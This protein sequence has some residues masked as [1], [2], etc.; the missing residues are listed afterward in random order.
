MHEVCATRLCQY[1]QDVKVSNSHALRP[2]TPVVR[3][4]HPSSLA[5]SSWACSSCIVSY[6]SRPSGDCKVSLF[7]N[8]HHPRSPSALRQLRLL[9][10][11]C[12]MP[13]QH[14]LVLLTLGPAQPS[15]LCMTQGDFWQLMLKASAA[16]RDAFAIFNSVSLRPQSCGKVHQGGS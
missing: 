3:V 4:V 10:Q 11:P 7:R 13:L 1:K 9:P 14:E 15:W 8:C 2:I 6:V 12:T 16:L 5:Q